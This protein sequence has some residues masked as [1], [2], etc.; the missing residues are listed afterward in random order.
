[1]RELG[2]GRRFGYSNPKGGEYMPITIT[3]HPFGFTVTIKIVK[4]YNRH[5]DK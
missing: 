4:K 5:S 2:D 1:M 3:F